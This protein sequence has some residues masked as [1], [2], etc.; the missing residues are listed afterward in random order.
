MNFFTVGALFVPGIISRLNS[1][2]G[3]IAGFLITTGILVWSFSVYASGD[4]I[5]FFL[6]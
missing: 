3:A 6:F 5:V 1:L 4:V 2:A